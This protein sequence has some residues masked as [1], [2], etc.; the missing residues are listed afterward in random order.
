MVNGIVGFGETWRRIVQALRDAAET[1]GW[2]IDPEQIVAGNWRG[3]TVIAPPSILVY[4][5]PGK[6]FDTQNVYDQVASLRVFPITPDGDD[7][8]HTTDHA[9]QLGW[10]IVE[11]LNKVGLTVRWPR[12]K[13]KID[14]VEDGWVAGEVRCEIWYRST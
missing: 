13:V 8:T 1:Q 12:D 2:D 4:L 10:K 3:D 5:R 6:D 11:V 7:I 14:T 9:V